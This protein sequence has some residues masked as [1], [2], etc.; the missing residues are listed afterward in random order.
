MLLH[1]HPSSQ[2]RASAAYQV[3]PATVPGFNG[4]E[5]ICNPVTTGSQ[6]NAGSDA[7]PFDEAI[8]QLGAISIIQEPPP[9]PIPA[10]FSPGASATSGL[11]GAC[12]CLLRHQRG[13]CMREQSQADT[14]HNPCWP[15]VRQLAAE[16]M[17]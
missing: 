4:A 12:L 10:G 6:I 9:C 5:A 17:R 8:P 16:L 1:S 15:L 3:N 7:F 2:I 13:M 14:M 11:Q